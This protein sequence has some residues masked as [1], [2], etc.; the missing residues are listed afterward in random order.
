MPIR[1][2]SSHNLNSFCKDYDIDLDELLTLINKKSNYKDTILESKIV[3][4]ITVIEDLIKELLTEGLRE[5]KSPRTVKYYLSFYYRL[6]R[7]L[8][9]VNSDILFTDLNEEILFNFIDNSIQVSKKNIGRSSINTYITLMKK[10]CTFAEEKGYVHKNLGYKFHKIKVHY[11]PRY[12]TNSQLSDIF[13]KVN[14]RRCPLLWSSLFL[15]LLGT[16]LRVQEL[17]NLKIKDINFKEDLIYTI[18]KGN[19][20]RYIPLYPQVKDT[21]KYYLATT[22]VED[23]EKSKESYVFSRVRGPVRTEPVSARSIQYN[24]QQIRKKLKMDSSFTVHSFRHTFAV[25]CLKANM[26]I[27]YLS[28]ILGHDSP[29]TTAIYTKLLPKDLKDEITNKFPLALEEL[30]KTV[31]KGDEAE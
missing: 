18:G 20:A 15:T 23:F 5:I 25:N 2:V 10:L 11:L 19:K 8:M 1:E 26:H 24:L 4:A 6:R 3:K 27:M 29:S 17:E 13:N 9:K 22:G 30:A 14:Q 16:G 31:I 28:Q 7:Y 21:L 12:F